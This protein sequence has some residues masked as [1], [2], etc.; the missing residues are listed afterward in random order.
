MTVK[1]LVIL[2]FVGTVLLNV[3]FASATNNP[4]RTEKN[5][6]NSFQLS[7]SRSQSLE[8]NFEYVDATCQSLGSASVEII[9]SV[10]GNP[11]I[12][13]SNGVV[14]AATVDNLSAGS[15]SVTI[16]DAGSSPQTF[17]FD[18]TAASI[19]LSISQTGSICAGNAS[20]TALV[21]VPINECTYTWSSGQHT[22]I[23]NITTA[24]NYHVTVTS[25]TCTADASINVSQNSFFTVNYTQYLCEDLIASATVNFT[26]GS[27][28]N[29]CLFNWTP[30]GEISQ[31]INITEIGSYSVNVIN[32]VTGCADT[33]YFAV[34]NSPDID[35]NLD[36]D[37]I[38]C[39]G[40][41]DGRIIVDASDGYSSNFTYQWSIPSDNDTIDNLPPG[42]YGLTVT[43]SLGCPKDTVIYLSE[44]DIFS[45]T[46]T[47]DTGFCAG[48][49]AVLRV[50]T[51]GGTAPFH[52]YWSDN[53]TVQHNSSTYQ[54][55]PAESFNYYVTVV[56]ANGCTSQPQLTRVVV[57][58]SIVLTTSVTDV[59]CHGI[60]NGEVVLNISGG[61]PPMTYSW[62]SLT[63]IWS[64]LCAGSYS[65]SLTDYYGCTA[66]TD[67][68]I[69]E[70]DTL[71]VEL[72]HGNATCFGLN[73]GFV[74]AFA[75]GGTAFSNGEYIY[76]W[77]NGQSSDSLAV[78]FGTY[79]VTV[80]DSK[81]CQQVA[82]VFVNAPQQ[83][84]LT[85]IPSQTI[86]I[87]ESV[88][89]SVYATGGVGQYDF[90]WTGSDNS[91]W[92]G[93][94]LQASPTTTTTYNVVATD[95]SGCQS[96][97]RIF[98]INV[99]P[100]L[101]IDSLSADK[102]SLC[103]GEKTIVSI[104]AGGGN[105]RPLNYFSPYDTYINVPYNFYPSESGYYTFKVTDD[106][107]TPAVTDSIYINVYPAPDV[108][109]TVDHL[110]SCPYVDYNFV[111]VHPDAGQTYRWDFGDGGF[112]ASKTPRYSYSQEGIY[113]VT[114]EVIDS[115]GCVGKNVMTDLIEIYPTP[116]A[117][118][119]ASPD[120]I[121]IADP[122]VTIEN[123]STGG[124][125]FFWNFG[126]GT[127]AVSEGNTRQFHVYNELGEF[128]VT[129][130]AKSD[131][132][133][134]DT[135]SKTI[136]IRDKYTFYAPTVFTPN[137]DTQN[138][139]FYIF[140]SGI[141]RDDFSLT[142]LDRFGEI[143][144]NT[145]EYDP[146]EPEKTAWDGTNK[147]GYQKINHKVLS[148]GVY[149]WR[150]KYVDLNGTS[151]EEYGTVLLLR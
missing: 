36:T 112:S 132:E 142:V 74:S 39:N 64:D 59:P 65:V 51:E 84:Y 35:I 47:N 33:K 20:L 18:I 52:Y 26:D 133:C 27:S 117:D 110:N 14:G 149:S 62:P 108:A 2:F 105:G 48:S 120:I 46:A 78:G 87:G 91:V 28:P 63:N 1:R 126:D 111:E 122:Y 29:D 22:P 38:S 88:E 58:P 53:P 45:Y 99:N 9:S 60:C 8:V 146:D 61:V 75:Y 93:E 103:Y 13:W 41:H 34:G 125:D 124:E 129:L 131:K 89:A 44:P 85:E 54:I 12:T 128:L 95:M 118:F 98:T 57:S 73:D 121:T 49:T 147:N 76:S 70:P 56:D 40:L 113:T 77:S 114:C 4:A 68:V 43:N 123:L 86:C 107:G 24:T 141:S 145:N 10:S 143:V 72:D 104:V 83:I 115:N 116:Y 119:L 139:Y 148:N 102:L 42:N 17:F 101:Q 135:A 138:D 109:F 66:N 16:E 144:F 69:S 82:S 150:C 5:P 140:G 80:T 31:S 7:N 67:F 151:H 96:S 55:S 37:N 130:I 15:Y 6:G 25:G 100:P 134:Y 137:G 50:F 127:D 23:I 90:V 94:H 79:T 21:D 11:V 30:G 106:C 136:F 81:N 71:L 3:S 32:N 97:G 92:Y 19:N